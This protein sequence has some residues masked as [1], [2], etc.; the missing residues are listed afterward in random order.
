MQREPCLCGLPRLSF[1]ILEVVCAYYYF[2]RLFLTFFF[3]NVSVIHSFTSELNNDKMDYENE[4]GIWEVVDCDEFEYPMSLL[5]QN[6]EFLF[7]YI[8]TFYLCIFSIFH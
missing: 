4:S 6:F 8:L 2:W 5:F 1:S 7:Y 3:Q